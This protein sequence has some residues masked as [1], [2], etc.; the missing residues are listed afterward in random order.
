MKHL[1][2]SLGVF[3][4]TAF[5]AQESQ[6]M[7]Y[8]SPTK[9]E[10]VPASK[11][12]IMPK[13]EVI[14]PNFKGRELI[15]VDQSPHHNLDWVW[16]QHESNQKSATA[17][18]LWQVQG[19]GANVSPPDPSGATD[20]LF[21][22]QGANGQGGTTVRIFNKQTGANVG[23][24][25]FTLSSK[26]SPVITGAGDPIFLYYKPAKRW[27]LTEFSSSGNR[28]LVYVSQTENPQ[29]AY[30]RYA[31]TCPN[32]PDYPKWSFS[33]SADA[34][35]VSTNEGG[36][37]TV[38]A[39]RLSSLL[40]GTASP[41]IRVPIGYSLNGFGFQSIT[42]VDLEGDNPAPAGMKPLFV[43]HRDDERHSNGSPDSNTNDWIE[44]WE[45]TINWGNNTATVAKVQDVAIAEIDSHLC[46][47]T[48]FQCFQQP[49]TN[50][51]LDPLRE[52]VMFK[53]PMR[54]FD[55]HQAMVLAL[56]T[57]VNGADRGG[58]RWI[59][60]RRA[61]G[62][63]GNW[64]LHQEG[65]YAPGTTNRWMPG[66]NM[67]K[68]GNIL[69]AYSTSSSTAGDFPSLRMTGRRACD[70]LGQ[71]TIPEI[72]IKTGLSSRT[73][74][75]RWGDYHH[76]DIDPIDGKTFYFTGVYMEAQNAIRTSVSAMR[77]DP[78]ATDAAVTNVFA[79]NPNGICGSSAEIAVVI[80]NQGT[81]A[82]SGGAFTW[83]VGNGTANTVNFTSNNLSANGSADTVVFIVNGL[84]S[85][86]NIIQINLTAINGSTPDENICNDQKS[87][88]L[89]TTGAA[90]FSTN[91]V[92]DQIPNC[93]VQNGQI[94]LNVSGGQAPF[95]YILGETTQSS[96]IFQNIGSGS[97]AYTIT[98]SEGC[99]VNGVYQLVAD[100]VVNL[101]AD[102]SNASCFGLQDGSVALTASGGQSPYT[103]SADGTDY[104]NSFNFSGLGSGL[105]NFFTLDA[106]G[107]AGSVSVNV[108]QPLAVS[109]NAIPTMISCNGSVDGS[110]TAAAQGGS[111]PY[112]FSIDGISFG[113]NNVFNGLSAGTYTLTVRDANECS[114]TFNTTITQPSPIVLNAFMTG[115]TGNDGTISMNASGGQTPYTFSI[116]GVNYFG[117]SFFSGLAP[118]TYT[119][120]VKDNNG[121][122]QTTS[123]TVEETASLSSLSLN[124][125]D[126]NLYPN[127][128]NGIFELEI[129][130]VKSGEVVCRLFNVSGIEV[131]TFQLEVLNGQVKK[132]MELSPKLAVGSY[133]LGVYNGEKAVVKQFVKQ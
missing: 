28:L 19:V 93:G 21:Y 22:V 89:E 55:T 124:I 106:N 63:L 75:T 101:T 128:N 127:P 107:C 3:A 72:T 12:Q 25:A 79:T 29:G 36:P 123:I 105:Y 115:S 131:A 98:D 66:I 88:T 90:G 32:F 74:N 69:M 112:S 56:T 122:I 121:C 67:D 91:I 76:M 119:C 78:Y 16:Q 71:M 130:G 1:F 125:H 97:Y 20:S 126:V 116:N 46:G 11:D 18:V 118:G 8:F 35:I 114:Q 117:G 111:A 42:P 113:T 85:G 30:N 81:S 13:H 73:S 24:N 27:F 61:A 51:R 17:S 83:Q 4:F 110:I 102:A 6:F 65:T 70:P 47:L 94:S 37:P 9:A 45:M 26:G 48:S 120:Y 57:D 52:T 64:T 100:V 96:P 49:G 84:V 31:F 86:N 62:S 5:F 104:V 103:Y 50:T 99:T 23:G 44:M 14:K 38:Y 15:E 95:V 132:T 92:V 87:I 54:V 39:M 77:I 41:F 2:T 7:G 59:E 109:L 58:I 10:L 133:Y 53:A 34:F 33:T 82:I 60:L 108:S 80:Q 68:D 129:K 40:A 43:R